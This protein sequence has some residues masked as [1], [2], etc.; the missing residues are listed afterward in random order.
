MYSNNKINISKMS[1]NFNLLLDEISKRPLLF[2]TPDF[3]LE[4]KNTIKDMFPL[5]GDNDLSVLEKIGIFIIEVI[6]NKYS[7]KN[8]PEYYEQW[9]QNN[10]RDIRGAI[11]LLLPFINDRDNSYLLKKITDLNQLLYAYKDDKIPRKILDEEREHIL[12]TSFEFGNMGI[13]LISNDNFYNNQKDLLDLYPNGGKLIYEVIHHNLIGLLQTLEIINGKCYVNWIN[14]V[15]LNLSNYTQSDIFTKTLDRLQTFRSLVNTRNNNGIISFLSD[16]LINYSGLWFGDI[17]NILRFKYYE[18]AKPIKWLFFPYEFNKNKMYLING[19][20]DMADLDSILNSNFNNYNDL[21]AETKII[22]QKKIENLITNIK[23]N[24]SITSLIQVD[25]D[26]LKYT[27][28]YLINNYS[29]NQELNNSFFKIFKLNEEPVNEDNDDF[30]VKDITRIDSISNE[31][32]LQCLELIFSNYID[33]FWNYLKESLVLLKNSA[34]GKFLISMENPN[35]YK[36]NNSYYYTPNNKKYREDSNYNSIF[37]QSINLKNIYN[38]AK[39]LSH[40]NLDSWNLL[41]K[42]YISLDSSNRILFFNKLYIDNTWIRLTGNL[43]RQ[44]INIDFDYNQ[45]IKKILDSFK[46]FYIYIVFEELV[47]NGILNN[48]IPNLEIT[49][50]LYLPQDFNPR[51]ETIKRLLKKAFDNNKEDWLNS[52]YYLTNDKFKNLPTMRLEKSKAISSKDKY[53][54]LPY[55]DVI[56]KDHEWPIFYAMDWISQISFFQHYIYHQILYVTGA[57]GQGKSTQVPKL[58]L[59]A[60]KMIDYKSNGKV[61]CTQP[62]IPPTVEN[63]SR[64]SDELGLSL[65]FSSNTSSYKIKSSNYYVQFKHQKDSHI[66]NKVQHSFLRVVTDGTLL[67]ELKSNPTLFTKIPSETDQYINK[68]IYDIVIVDEAHEHNINMDLIITMT[69]QACYYNNTIKLIIVSATMDDDEPIYRRYFSSI[70]DNL[71]FPIKSKIK[72]PLLNDFN[73][74]PLSNYMDRRYHISP[75]GET[76]QYRVDDIYLDYDPEVYSKDGTVDFRAS[77]KEAQLLGYKK[78]IEICNKTTTGQIL[79]FANGMREIMEA[80]EYL[81]ANTPSG[82][83][84]LPYFSELN[85]NYKSVISKI[86]LKISS[87]KNRRDRIHLEWGQQYIEDPTVP[88]G[89]YKRAIIVATN[90]AEASVTIPGLSFVIDNGYSKVNEY[91]P[92]LN[93]TV[94]KVDKIS[95]S[96]RLQ[97]RG[98]VGRIGDGTVY[99]MYKKDSRKFIKPKYKITQE[100]T[101]ISMLGLL[102]EKNVEDIQVDDYKNYSK[103]IISDYI[104][105]NI[106]G[107]NSFLNT[108]GYGH[109]S[110]LREIYKQNYYINNKPLDL[111]YYDNPRQGILEYIDPTFIA[112]NTGQ[113]IDNI[114]DTTCNF[115]LIHP[116]ENSIKRNVLNNIITYRSARIVYTKSVRNNIPFIPLLEYRFIISYLFNKNLLVDS[117]GDLLYNSVSDMISPNRKYVKTELGSKLISIMSQLQ[118]SVEDCLTL[119]SASGMNCL[120]QV[121]EVKLFLDTIGSLSN[122]VHPHIKWETFMDIYGGPKIKSDITFIYEVIKSIKSYFNNLLVFNVETQ[123]MD[124]LIEPQYNNVLNNF[125]RMSERSTE[126]PE[127]FDGALWNKLLTLRNG[128]EL[129]KQAKS[130]IIGDISTY[131]LVEKDIDKYQDQIIKWAS[132]NM[133][134]PEIIIKYLK[135]LG[136]FY[137]NRELTNNKDLLWCKNLNFIKTL[138]TTDINEKIIRSFMFGRPQQFT[139]STNNKHTV[140]TMLNSKKYGIIFAKSRSN[141]VETLTKTSNNLIFY[142]SYA[143]IEDPNI[144]GE[145][146]LLNVSILSQI[147]ADW[148]VPAIPLLINPTF[149]PDVEVSKGI[150]DNTVEVNFLRSDGLERLK[151][152]ILNSWNRGNYIWNSE[153]TP[154]LDMFYKKITKVM[155]KHI[156]YK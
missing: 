48:F 84:T 67:E 129:D 114:L 128:G 72:H 59:Y 154:I 14:I 86:N 6:S 43:K 118:M 151:R 152:E 121:F 5:L 8:L 78:I 60:L 150:R 70:N 69:K 112:F 110:G 44:F 35:K 42:N 68:N 133:F 89:Q 10:A 153:Y 65:D 132:Y 119:M 66:N 137:L 88:T 85:D 103:L 146:N 55:F 82:N 3:S 142:L 127:N 102:S 11:L 29:N 98:R 32:I 104:N 1:E 135:D 149:I 96:S 71:M 136:Y 12:S 18:E 134:N 123:F 130:V 15:P 99:Y 106:Y 113:V 79:F 76:T 22:F 156:L 105:P 20:N 9:T 41:D 26:I 23:I 122:I 38:I 147:N 145:P 49:N 31:D 144:L 24:K 16:N 93:Q 108:V 46:L 131:R 73:F 77:A 92:E 95:E 143:E 13:S 117:V 75:P 17:Y 58:L 138:S 45:E 126:P 19:L 115:Y 37:E 87:I 83:I 39:S 36:I 56:T 51:K 109:N 101:A 2:I 57:T 21:D 25:Y 94:L 50:K 63:A 100:N 27:F 141:A 62:R 53:D 40:D 52:Y 34:Y 125:L 47:T 148:L 91:V 90:V 80:V 33:H 111:D 120:T 74:L 30:N 4:I 155:S 107:L 54:E 81:N 116:F 28:I 139:F 97:R 124:K 64:I 61:I 140:S 7:F